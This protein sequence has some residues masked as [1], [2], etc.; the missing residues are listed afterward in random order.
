MDLVQGRRRLELFG[1]DHN[2]RPGWVTIGN[3]L[4]GSNFNSQVHKPTPS[5]LFSIICKDFFY[6]LLQ[7]DLSRSKQTPDG[8]GELSW[9]VCLQQ[10]AQRILCN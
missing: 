3:A 1:E 2:I 9:D 8:Q 6:I 4:V 5:C 10:L 7:Q